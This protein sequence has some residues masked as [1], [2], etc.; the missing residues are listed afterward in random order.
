VEEEPGQK[1]NG[2][3]IFISGL[4][5]IVTFTDAVS[6]HPLAFVPMTEYVPAAVTVIDA[7]VAPVLHTYVAAPVAVSVEE[8][9]GQNDNGPEIFTSGLLLTVTF[10]DAV[11]EHPFPLVP[12]TLYVPAVVTVIEVVVSPV[13][14]R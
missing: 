6:A 7:V 8:E 4:V 11:S 2:P 9:P 3:E 5:L 1:D 13:L 14:Q 12:T 10:I